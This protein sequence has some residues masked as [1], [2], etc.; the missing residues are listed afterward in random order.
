M[1]IEEHLNGQDGLICIILKQN[2]QVSIHNHY[3][4]NVLEHQAILI[5]DPQMMITGMIIILGIQEG[6]FLLAGNVV[7]IL[8][9]MVMEEATE[10]VTEEALVVLE[11]LEI[12]IQMI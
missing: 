2:Y 1:I 8:E 10:E 12:I 11:I 9:V 6:E 4:I 7:V 3:I 5:E